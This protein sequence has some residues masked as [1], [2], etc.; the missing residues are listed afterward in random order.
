MTRFGAFCDPDSPLLSATSIPHQEAEHGV[1]LRLILLPGGPSPR[2]DASAVE[3]P[4]SPAVAPQMYSI[5]CAEGSNSCS[6]MLISDSSDP[7]ITPDPVL[8]KR[9]LWIWRHTSS[10]G[11]P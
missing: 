11:Q 2:G 10:T 6:P 8:A 7:G 9:F 1:G 5:G 3:G 4:H